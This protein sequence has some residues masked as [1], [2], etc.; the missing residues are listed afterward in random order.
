MSLE[1]DAVNLV[2]EIINNSK[3]PVDRVKS[4]SIKWEDISGY[5]LPKVEFIF[6]ETLEEKE[7]ADTK[8]L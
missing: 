6:Y 1:I 4:F 3:L 7:N 8:S 5:Y 2:G